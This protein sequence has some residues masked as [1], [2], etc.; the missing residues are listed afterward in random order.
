VAG[1]DS[2]RQA[3]YAFAQHIQASGATKRQILVLHRDTVRHADSTA[4]YY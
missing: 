3:K 2:V 1:D 4:R